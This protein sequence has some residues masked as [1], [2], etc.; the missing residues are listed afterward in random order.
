MIHL[1]CKEHIGDILLYT[2]DTNTNHETNETNETNETKETNE[3]STKN[4]DT[5]PKK[6]YNSKR[7]Q[8]QIHIQQTQTIIEQRIKLKTEKQYIPTDN[9]I[10]DI[11][12][13]IDPNTHIQNDWHTTI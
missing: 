1:I 7:L 13:L 8:E 10:H 11:T 6:Q 4:N 2:T 12:K 9:E 5:Q 3:N